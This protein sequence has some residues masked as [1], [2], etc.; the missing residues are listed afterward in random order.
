MTDIEFPSSQSIAQIQRTR[1]ISDFDIEAVSRKD[2][3]LPPH[4]HRQIVT[5]LELD[6]SKFCYKNLPATTLNQQTDL[7]VTQASVS[8]LQAPAARSR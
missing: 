2:S 6:Q 3:S 8:M 1:R 5:G 4:M 7:S